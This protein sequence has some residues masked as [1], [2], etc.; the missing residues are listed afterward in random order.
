[1]LPVEHKKFEVSA[2]KLEKN[3]NK[4]LK[5][6]QITYQLSGVNWFSFFFFS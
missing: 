1:M 5:N 6:T 3:H 2:L 4:D